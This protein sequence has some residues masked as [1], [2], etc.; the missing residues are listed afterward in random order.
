M[1]YQNYISGIYDVSDGIY[2]YW[3][4]QDEIHWLQQIIQKHGL[5]SELWDEKGFYKW[6]SKK[7]YEGFKYSET[8]EGKKNEH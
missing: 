7:E 1:A 8:T 2:K 6:K 5:R 3:E 4:C